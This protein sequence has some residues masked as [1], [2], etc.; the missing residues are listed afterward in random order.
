MKPANPSPCA[1][2]PWR[3]ENHNKPHPLGWYSAK[4]R[5]RLWAQL[6]NGELMSCHPTDPSNEVPEGVKPVAESVEPHECTGALI[7]QQREMMRLQDSVNFKS[8]RKEH[9]SGITIVGGRVLVGR[10][11]CFPGEVAMAK[12][13]L[14]EP[15]I[16]HPKLA[17]WESR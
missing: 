15:G 8:Y 12:P 9:P 3:T 17:D 1:A 13:N 5:A 2:C 16:G 4:N 14:N 6:R 7:L 11:I 10:L